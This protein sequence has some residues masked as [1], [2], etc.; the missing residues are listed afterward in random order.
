MVNG[1]IYDK[2]PTIYHNQ[3]VLTYMQHF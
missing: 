2:I 1:T 3:P